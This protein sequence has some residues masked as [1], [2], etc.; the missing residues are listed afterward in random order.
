MAFAT[1]AGAGLVTTAFVSTGSLPE[2]L[3][4]IA[5]ALLIELRLITNLLDGMV[6]VE[7]GKLSPLGGL[8]N[9][10]PDRLSDVVVLVGLGYASGGSAAAGFAASIGALLT[11]YVRALGVTLGARNHFAG[12][13]AKPHRMHLVA[14]LSA[15]MAFAPAAWREHNIVEAVLW[16]VAGLCVMTV[17][18][19]LRLIVID[20]SDKSNQ[21]FLPDERRR[22]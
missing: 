5:A 13:L 2:R 8:F 11:A 19:R 18:N 4:W 15:V 22:P 21:E 3:A 12:P 1:A 17:I 7:G 14:A 10:A 9:E 16:V 6:A 20:L